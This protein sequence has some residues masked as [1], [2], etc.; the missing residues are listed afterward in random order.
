LKE[1]RLTSALVGLFYPALTDSKIPT[2][3]SLYGNGYLKQGN[4]EDWP[5]FA[6]VLRKFAEQS[7]KIPEVP[8]K[9]ADVP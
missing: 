3:V 2:E 7:W 8:R 9:S 4:A 1:E 6:E 5:V